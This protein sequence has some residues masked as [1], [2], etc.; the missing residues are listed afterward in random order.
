[1]T[2]FLSN[3]KN[4]DMEQGLSFQASAPGWLR[5]LIESIQNWWLKKTCPEEE[6]YFLIN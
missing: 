5:I 4:R 6:N 3:N 2:L 1:M